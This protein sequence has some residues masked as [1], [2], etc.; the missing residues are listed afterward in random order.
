MKLRTPAMTRAALG[1]M[2][3]LVAG[4]CATAPRPTP[5]PQAPAP[6]PAVRPAPTPAPA[7]LPVAGAWDERPVIEGSWTYD[8]A[9]RH[10]RF[11]DDSGLERAD[12]LCTAPGVSMQLGLAGE[13]GAAVEV[14]TSAG[15]GTHALSGGKAALAV[16][17]ITLDR[18]A[19]SR[20]RFA[21]R[22]STLLVL[23]VQAE[24]GRVIEDCRG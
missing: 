17:D 20:G 22:A 7:P 3:M 8:T 9:R 14:L 5:P 10:A 18:I 1:T 24:I 13:K 23:P 21:L 11:V 15:A 2:L 12:L 4:S 6:P 19:F 16:R